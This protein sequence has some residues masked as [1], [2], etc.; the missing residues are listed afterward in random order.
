MTVV[1]SWRKVELST[2]KAPL[3]G[4]CRVF[5]YFDRNNVQTDYLDI[6][7]SGHC[8]NWHKKLYLW[9]VKELFTPKLGSRLLNSVL[10]KSRQI[11]N[12]QKKTMLRLKEIRYEVTL[13]GFSKWMRNFSWFIIVFYPDLAKNRGVDWH[14][15]GG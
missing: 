11:F 8:Q 15:A 1:D 6:F 13:C 10:D 3:T 5:C 7:I 14:F 2:L 4:N 12:F 9:L